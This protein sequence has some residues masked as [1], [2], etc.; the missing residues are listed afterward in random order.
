[1]SVG[2]ATAKRAKAVTER[3]VPELVA[4]VERDEIKVSAANELTKLPPDKQREVLA[5][6][7]AKVSE[8]V[9][10]LRA[11]PPVRRT[12]LTEAEQ[13][14]RRQRDITISVDQLAETV[15]TVKDAVQKLSTTTITPDAHEVLSSLVGDLRITADWLETITKG[16]GVPD[17][18]PASWLEDGKNQ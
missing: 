7:K 10:E 8:T 12:E 1:M 15:L 4:A 5:G 16:Q 18:V 14:A 9:R 2:S 17:S 11:K 3:G 13:A 6:G